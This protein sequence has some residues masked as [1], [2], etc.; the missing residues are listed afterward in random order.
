LI[1]LPYDA[2]G[3]ETAGLV[4]DEFLFAATPDHPLA[5]VEHLDA[6]MLAGEPLLLLEDGHCLR[7]HALA[8]CSAGRPEASDARS[9]F[10]ATSLHTLVQMVK[11]GLGATLLPKLAVDAG[12]ADR[13]DLTIRRFDPPVSGREIGMAWRKGS[14][15]AEEARML[16]DAIREGLRG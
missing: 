9:D 14:A 5:K 11:S 10:A 16:S 15:R 2:P 8:V 6:D 3:I 1:A 12:L 7:D 13:L 4:E